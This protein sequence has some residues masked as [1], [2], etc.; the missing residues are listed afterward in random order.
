MSQVSPRLARQRRTPDTETEIPRTTENGSLTAG[1]CPPSLVFAYRIGPVRARSSV[2]PSANA[3][4]CRSR[5][6][7]LLLRRQHLL[8][9]PTD[10]RANQFAVGLEQQLPSELVRHQ[11]VNRFLRWAATHLSQSPRFAKIRRVGRSNVRAGVCSWPARIL[12]H[13]RLCGT[14]AGPAR[15]STKGSAW[16]MVE[17]RQSRPKF[18]KFCSSGCRITL[19]EQ[20][21]V[22][23]RGSRYDNRLQIDE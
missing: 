23:E 15:G 8:V 21:D 18:L 9:V 2:L 4:P 3:S 6:L 11:S 7:P 12:F 14:T 5:F 13:Q 19:A 16:V 10:L 22:E 17:T 1:A 20:P